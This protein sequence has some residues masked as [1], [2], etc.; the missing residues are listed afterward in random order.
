MPL[1][2]PKLASIKWA[3]PAFLRPDFWRRLA[4]RTIMLRTVT[5]RL[6]LVQIG[7]FAVFSLALLGFVY[8]ATVVQTQAEADASVDQEFTELEKVYDKDGMNALNQEVFERA[9]SAGPQLYILANKE[10]EIVAGDFGAFPQLPTGASQ[11]VPFEYKTLGPDGKTEVNRARGRIGR[12]G[13]GPILLVARDMANSSVL[14]GRVTRAVYFGAG[15]GFILSLISGYFASRQAARRAEALSRTAQDVMR[16]DLTRR[17]PVV[18]ANDEFDTLAQDLNAMLD[19][20]E[21]LMRSARTAGDAIAHDLRTPLTRL[22]SRLEAAIESTPN[23]EADR[24]ALRRALEETDSLLATFTAVLRLARVQS[25]AG[26]Q[27][28]RVDLSAIARDLVEFYEPVAEDGGVSLASD[29]EDGLFAPGEASL[30][31]Q[32]LSNLIEN[33]IKYTPAPGRV[34]VSAKR[35]ERIVLSVADTGPGVPPEER[36]RVI[37]RFVRLETARSTPGAGLGLSLV[38]AVAEV[39]R[40]DLKLEDGLGGAAGPGLRVTLTLPVLAAKG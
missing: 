24:E 9:S 40:A 21:R 10:G 15:L 20:I 38:A 1:A 25:A 12:V 31:T 28:Q 30:L 6:A 23:E 33:A 29:I 7:L 19:R 14:V 26:W 13:N 36:E 3:R 34:H 17:A 35:G 32:A 27:F 11:R 37:D 22:R 16:G 5:F 8:Y 4:Q 2:L 39:H 18:G